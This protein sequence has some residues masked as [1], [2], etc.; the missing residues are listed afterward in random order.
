MRILLVDDDPHFAGAIKELLTREGHEVEIA[1]DGSQAIT[2]AGRSRP[3]VVVLDFKMPGFNG[4]V[5]GRMLRS[6]SP[7]AHIIGVSGLP[8]IG[9]TSWADAFL[10]KDE[11]LEKLPGAIAGLQATGSA[12]EAPE[13][14]S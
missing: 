7:G 5:T 11:V 9:D 3:E 10:P 13:Q 6:F 1:W 12:T 8:D 14:P 2:A 4:A